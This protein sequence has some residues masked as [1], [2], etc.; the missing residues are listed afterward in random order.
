[1]KKIM[2]RFFR[3]PVYHPKA[4]LFALAIISA[5][6]CAGMT[7]IKFENS[8]DVMMP[9]SDIEYITN[10]SIK[11]IYGNNGK[12]II[13]GINSDTLFTGDSFRQIDLLIREIEE[14]S[15]FHE[16]L[17]SARINRIV[18][19]MQEGKPVTKSGLLQSISDDPVF[20]SS[21]SRKLGTSVSP[22]TALTPGELKKLKK[23]LEKSRDIKKKEFVDT[24]LSPLTMKDLSGKDDT[25]TAYNLVPED[26]NGDRIL[27]ATDEEFRLFTGKLRR[28]PAFKN[29]LYAENSEGRITDFGILIRLTESNDQNEIARELRTIAESYNGKEGMK[30]I[31]QGAPVLYRQ[32]TDYMQSDLRFFV[33]IVLF[34]ICVIFYLNFRTFQGVV[35]PLATLLMADAWVLGLMGFLGVKISVIGISLPPLI[36]SVGSSYSIH[37]MNRFLIDSEKIREDRVNGLI[38]SMRMVGMTLLLASTTTIVGFTANMA[39]RVSSIFEWGIFAALGTAFAVVI[40]A[41]FIPAVFSLMELKSP[42]IKKRKALAAGGGK[43]PVTGLLSFYGRLATSHPRKVLAGT[44]A[45]IIFSV[46]GIFQLKAET[47]LQ[48][49]FKPSDYI[50]TSNCEI[51][52]KFGGT[53]GI[54]ILIDSGEMDGIKNPEFLNRVEELRRW[55]T[56]PENADLHIGRTEG[57]GDFIRT[58]NMAM[59]ND[60]PAFYTIPESEM[61]LFDYFEIYTGD[62]NNS[63]GRVDEFEPYVDPEFRTLNIFA[64]LS[65]TENSMLGTSDISR[66]VETIRNHFTE[67]LSPSGYKV[68]VSG[69][70]LIIIS[71]AKYIVRG[72][73]WSLFLSLIAVT[74]IVMVLFRSRGAG[75]ISAV[76]IATAV[77]VNFGVMGWFG[78]RLDIATAIIASITIGIGVDNTIHFLNTYRH[79]LQAGSSI[80]EAIKTA[81]LTGGKAIIFTALAL[82]AGFS[83]LVISQFKPILLFGVMMGFTFIATTTG[84]ILVLPALIRATGFT[85]QEESTDRTD[86]LTDSPFRILRSAFEGR[87]ISTFNSSVRNNLLRFL[88]SK[89]VH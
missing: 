89:D 64:R 51:G 40:A 52:R 41:L 63:D 20:A 29:G 5:M 26:E 74:V 39:T 44:L 9:R 54:N 27:P 83:V 37:I 12:F 19:F 84:A 77:I 36:I 24:I 69:E 25:L 53:M 10:N 13:F 6:A 87:H 14:Y 73:L 71:L 85:L 7:Q 4:T 62:D 46:A 68:K 67:E 58:I 11:E 82:I 80:D 61:D 32:I 50:N 18:S 76:P 30:I 72:Q 38:G 16:E 79:S 48:S 45:V 60:N 78:I 8:L 70:P 31:A 55:L 47:S 49:Y 1:M 2:D 23:S 57:F 86:S 88:N 81:L 35:I 34:V 75:L 17:E 56:S 66:I 28:N 42:G 21:V 22:D 43:S 65:E 33:P 15:S 59:H 3:L